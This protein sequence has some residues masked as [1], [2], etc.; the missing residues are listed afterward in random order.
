M[1]SLL[2]VRRVQEFIMKTESTSLTSLPQKKITTGLKRLQ[3]AGLTPD[4][5]LKMLDAQPA[6]LQRIVAAF[7]GAPKPVS[8]GIGIV[9]DAVAMSR[10]LGITCECKDP[11]PEAADGEVVIYY[12]GWD[13]PTLRK[14]AA[15]QKRMWQDQNWYDDKGWKVEPGYYRVLLRVPDSN[16]RNWNEQVNHLKTVDE[17]WQPAPVT[18]AATALLVHLTET[19]ND[20]LRNDWCRC[21]EPLPC[22]DHAALTVDHGRVLVYDRRWDGRRDDGHLWLSAARKS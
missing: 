9:Y 2:P 17:A 19:G 21:A 18:V 15:G 4:R 5:W 22:D 20:L 6:E 10:I 13:L 3:E 8:T 16:R 1:T 7:P 14:S 11:V 12:G